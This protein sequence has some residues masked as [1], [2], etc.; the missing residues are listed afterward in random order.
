[1]GPCSHQGGREL[2]RENHRV[3]FAMNAE[4]TCPA[5]GHLDEACPIHTATLVTD[6]VT[7]AMSRSSV[8]DDV[9]SPNE[10]DLVRFQKLIEDKNLDDGWGARLYAYWALTPRGFMHPTWAKAIDEYDVLV[11]ES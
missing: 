10:K 11:G 1:M 7:R 9:K 2:R 3:S 5:F 4:C 8:F 6:S